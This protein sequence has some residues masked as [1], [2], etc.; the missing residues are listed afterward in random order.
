MAVVY[1]DKVQQRPRDSVN[2]LL[3]DLQIDVAT[4][5]KIEVMMVLV[6]EIKVYRDDLREWVMYFI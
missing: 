6:G 3:A 5:R 2:Y 4:D 1:C